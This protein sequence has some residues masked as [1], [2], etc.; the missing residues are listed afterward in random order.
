MNY[1]TNYQK[2]VAEVGGIV[3]DAAQQ[4]LLHRFT[5]QRVDQQTKRD[6]SVVTEADSAMQNRLASLLQ[7]KWPE[8]AFLGEEMSPD[9]QQQMVRSNAV[10]CLD[11][12]DGTSN[13]ASGIPFFAVSLAL[14]ENQK[15]TLGLIYDP[16]RDE[17][18]TAIKG[19]GCRL[20]GDPLSTR[21]IHTRL[22][23]LKQMIAVVDLKRL[24]GPVLT[25]LVVEHPFRS[26][27]NFG[28]CALEWCWLAAG[29][30]QL[31]IHGGQKLWDYAAGTLILEEAGGAVS[32]LSGE[33][34]FTAALEPR[35]VVAAYNPSAHEQWLAWIE[36][37]NKQD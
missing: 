26:Q 2:I 22:T 35:P 32:T 25:S 3:R 18:F 36:N 12:L 33:E 1:Q 23:E 28:S 17:C 19:E 34:V 4:E 6:G 14:I 15:Q 27:R 9:E 16:V 24:R 7:E 11:P 37:H 21:N 29:R 13:F 31:Y 5:S 20:N 10:W 8:I 30:F